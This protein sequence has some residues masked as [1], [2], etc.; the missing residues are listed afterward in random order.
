MPR[1]LSQEQARGILR[2]L[3]ALVS[4]KACVDVIYIGPNTKFICYSFDGGFGIS[5]EGREK[6]AFDTLSEFAAFYNLTW[7]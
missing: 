1:I 5:H 7:M 3:E 2:T 4:I 6:E